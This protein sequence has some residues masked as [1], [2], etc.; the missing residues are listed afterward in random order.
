MI[1]INTL[2]CANPKS[3]RDNTQ[4]VMMVAAQ[5][6]DDARETFLTSL[7]EDPD[8]IFS[9]NQLLERMNYATVTI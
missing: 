2:F 7:E 3:F 4:K 5:L 6:N 9:Y 1:I 8:L